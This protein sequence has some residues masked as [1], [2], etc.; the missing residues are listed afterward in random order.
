[1]IIKKTNVSARVDCILKKL[2]EDSKFS[3]KDAYELGAKLIAI[4]NVENTLIII[5]KNSNFDKLERQM[6]YKIIL[7]KKNQLEKELEELRR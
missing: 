7:D 6:K 1:M 2:V 5:H 4:D 3:H